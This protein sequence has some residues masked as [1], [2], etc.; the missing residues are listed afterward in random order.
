MPRPRNQLPVACCKLQPM[1]HFETDVASSR[2]CS[3][4]ISVSFAIL[5][6]LKSLKGIERRRGVCD[7]AVSLAINH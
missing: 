7:L 5:L 2:V 3:E 4:P 6:S 1:L